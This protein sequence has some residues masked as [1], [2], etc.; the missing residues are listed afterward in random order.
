[1]NGLLDREQVLGRLVEVVPGPVGGPR[2]GACWGERLVRDG[3]CVVPPGDP[4]P[5]P[6]RPT[7]H[8]AA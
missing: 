3:P 5:E 2:A 1:M 7:R 8:R 4:R 6:R